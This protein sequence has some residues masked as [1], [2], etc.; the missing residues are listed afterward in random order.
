[1]TQRVP[2][3]WASS[4]Q[5]S[6]DYSADK[7][8]NGDF[9]IGAQQRFLSDSQAQP[10]T[11][12][13]DFGA[14]TPQTLTWYKI[15]A[16]SANQ[17]PAA[18][19]FRGSN[20][21]TTWDVLDTR[22]AITYPN[23]TTRTFTFANTTAYRYYRLN[24]TATVGGTS[25]YLS[26]AELEM[27]DGH[28]FSVLYDRTRD[29][30]ITGGTYNMG[31]I[32]TPD[33]DGTLTH[34]AFHRIGTGTYTLR[35]YSSAGTVLTSQT[36]VSGGAAGEF[37]VA[38]TAPLAVTAGTQ[39]MVAVETPTSF[40]WLSGTQGSD[41]EWGD[42]NVPASPTFNGVSGFNHRRSA[43]FG[44]IPDIS[45]AG[46]CL[47]AVRFE[48]ATASAVTV[49]APALSLTADVLD[50]TVAAVTPQTVA[51]PAL[52]VTIN[53]PA[54]VVV[55]ATHVTVAAPV[56]DLSVAVPAPVVLAESSAVTV[57]APSLDLA[58]AVPAPLVL[59]N[60]QTAAPWDA[61]SFGLAIVGIVP[62]VGVFHVD[63][64]AAA[65]PAEVQPIMLTRVSHQIPAGLITVNAD[66]EPVPIDE[67][68]Y[69]IVREDMGHLRAWSGGQDVTYLQGK[70]TRI[71]SYS[72]ALPFGERNAQLDF[73]QLMLLDAPPT[74]LDGDK[75]V[76]I[77]LV[78]VDGSRINLWSGKIVARSGGNAETN[79]RANRQC[80]GPL[81]SADHQR[82]QVPLMMPTVDR[83]KAVVD[84]LNGTG[85]R[86][87]GTIAPATTGKFTQERGSSN[88]TRLDYAQNQ[89][90]QLW[91][92]EADQWTVA[93]TTTPRAYQL[94][95][96]SAIGQEWTLTYGA[97][98][99]QVDLNRDETQRYNVIWG[100][101]SAT[102]SSG[103]LYGWQNMFFPG[104][105]PYDPPD[106]P[107]NAPIGPS[108]QIELGTTDADTD[109]GDGVTVWQT[110][111]VE[112]G[113]DLDIN[114]VA[115]PDDIT[116][117]LA[118]QRRRGILDDGNGGPQTWN[119]TWDV[120]TTGAALERIRLP[121]AYDPR[122]W[123]TL[124][125]ANGKIIGPNPDYDPT[126]E[127]YESEDV[128]YPPG[129]TKAQAIVSAQEDL[130]RNL[131]PGL[132]GTITLTSCPWEGWRGL[133]REGD[134]VTLLGYEGEDV[135]LTV[136]ECSAAP[137][138]DFRVTLQVDTK[139]RDA[140]TLASIAALDRDSAA[141]LAR[142]PGNTNRISQIDRNQSTPFEGESPAGKLPKLAIN[143][144]AG[145]WT[146]WPVFVSETGQLAFIDLRTT[147]P[148]CEFSVGLFGWAPTPNQMAQYVGDPLTDPDAWETN[149][150]LLRSRFGYINSWG[151]SSG[152]AGRNSKG[153]V[154]GREFDDSPLSFVSQKAGWLFVAIYAADFTSITGR[155][156][157]KWSQ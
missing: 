154:D 146:V 63:Y 14:G 108:D 134:R 97:P 32:F 136:A 23:Q 2:T 37:D 34:Y 98:G 133:I 87:F 8:G 122:V 11:L 93:R 102:D 113:Y 85:S 80:E 141:D 18:F 123:P 17:E 120:G 39:Y 56:L 75:P 128:E 74:V 138:D 35:I 43:A 117:M 111:M 16:G 144:G 62:P 119:A 38:L 60:D 45:L 29:P 76:D 145:L 20:D 104:L 55:E 96:K 88:D 28:P 147:G 66:G 10:W 115:G 82:H 15:T 61:D 13:A 44:S 112:L 89:L 64:P 109:S 24:V 140:M 90:A 36:H 42:L 95:L 52:D 116:A 78:K 126:I 53:L 83:G 3:S 72:S 132:N 143:G 103:Y 73:P 150:E 59:T 33:V 25:G 142:K 9:R 77:A 68:D 47:I 30:N 51:P 49:S 124:H 92:P 27:G 22:S 151:N 139:A 5:F 67:A 65:V 107:W 6:A 21:G 12:T 127:R 70:A 148:A 135:V 54:P 84:E 152:P 100:H 101:G 40:V 19:T 41:V 106:F 81:M 71:S 1:M 46:R 86:T 114:G 94:A 137:H 149:L 125:A 58:I 99:V 130:E 153:V 26:L 121:L 118:L 131:D 31:V 7:A 110:R 4:S 79:V 69:P 105:L 57:A 155:I 91:T 50:P 48:R 129:T 157:P 156:Y